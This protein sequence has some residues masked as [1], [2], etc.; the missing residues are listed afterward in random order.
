MGLQRDP[1]LVEP[2]ITIEGVEL[3]YADALG[4]PYLVR[5]LIQTRVDPDGHVETFYAEGWPKN[6]LRG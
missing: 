5:F 2:N 3:T 6:R 4:N 1:S